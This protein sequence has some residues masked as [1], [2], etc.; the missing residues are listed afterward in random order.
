ML[1]MTLEWGGICP[2]V[3]PCIFFKK[4]LSLSALS[5]LQFTAGKFPHYFP[6]ISYTLCKPFFV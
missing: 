6:V 5:G 1:S 4:P 3:S 2:Y